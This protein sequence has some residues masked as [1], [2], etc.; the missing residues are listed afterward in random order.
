MRTP[1]AAKHFVELLGRVIGDRGGGVF[2]LMAGQNADD[3]L[4]GA[5]DAFGHE[6][7][8]ARHAGGAGR[9]AAEA[10]GADLG[11]GVE[12]FLVG[13]FA[14]HAVAP[15]Q[16]PQALGQVD[17]PVDFDGAGDGRGP[18]AW[19]SISPKYRSAIVPV[20][21]AVVESQPA[22]LDQ[23]VERVGPGGVDHGQPGNAVDQP[24]L[25]Q[26]VKRL[27]ESAAVAQVSAGHGDPIGRLPAA[28]P[29]ARGT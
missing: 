4:V 22:M 7:L 12:D 9:L 26:F 13:H 18:A 25:V 10:A 17:R 21:L 11:L 14:D 8:D 24:Q 29:P 16:G 1:R 23:L 3:L 20:R 19:A 15:L 27:A 2:Q 5:D 6:L 28:G